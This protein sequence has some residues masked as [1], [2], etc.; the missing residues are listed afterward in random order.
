ME[1]HF[2]CLRCTCAFFHIHLPP[3]FQSHSQQSWEC[4]SAMQW[5]PSYYK[6]LDWSRKVDARK[7][8]WSRKHAAHKRRWYQFLNAMLKESIMPRKWCEMDNEV[9]NVWQSYFL[10]SNDFPGVIG[11]IALNG[12]WNIV[13]SS[14]R[15]SWKR[16]QGCCSRAQSGQTSILITNGMVCRPTTAT[17]Q[18]DLSRGRGNLWRWHPNFCQVFLLLNSSRVY[19]CNHECNLCSDWEAVMCVMKS[20]MARHH[21]HWVFSRCLSWKQT[22][23]WSHLLRAERALLPSKLAE[24]NTDWVQTFAEKVMRSCN[25][26]LF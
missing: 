21:G 23:V 3:C 7:L 18:P 19:G 4:K 22:C 8:L 14:W 11:E 16:L 2:V 6:V 1:I 24:V 26:F 25:G 5:F 12:G 17:G 9:D 15:K 13:I 10:V 20:M